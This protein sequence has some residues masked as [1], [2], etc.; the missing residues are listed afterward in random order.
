MDVSGWS[1]SNANDRTGAGYG[2]R[3][4]YDVRDRY[5]PRSRGPVEVVLDSGEVVDASLSE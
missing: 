4:P 2:I 1:N 3:I 5:F